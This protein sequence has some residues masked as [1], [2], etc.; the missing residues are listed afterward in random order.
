MIPIPESTF[1]QMADAGLEARKREAKRPSDAAICSASTTF[2]I[3]EERS[4]EWIDYA[5]KDTAEIVI[6]R[7][8][9]LKAEKPARVFRGII[10]VISDH[11]LPN[12]KEHA[13]LSAGASVEL[14]V[15][16]ETT[17]DHVNRAADRGCCVS[18]C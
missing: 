2:Y 14:G 7:L 6:A 10:R 15:D 9:E 3:Q 8:A 16:V 11:L 18:T 12:V 17:E 5:P 4:G 1:N 13:T